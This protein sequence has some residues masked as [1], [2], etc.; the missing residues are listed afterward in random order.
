MHIISDPSCCSQQ[1]VPFA[2]R[3]TAHYVITISRLATVWTKNN[4]FVALQAAKTRKSCAFE[5]S[6]PFS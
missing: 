6:F 2:R 5:S 4:H 1:L 3:T